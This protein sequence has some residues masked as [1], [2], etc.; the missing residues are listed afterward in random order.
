[1]GVEPPHLVAWRGGY[2]DNSGR[3][4]QGKERQ[5]RKGPGRLADCPSFERGTV[6]HRRKRSDLPVFSQEVVTGEQRSVLL[7]PV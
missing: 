7:S 1:V 4:E 3:K 5:G 6:H 2:S